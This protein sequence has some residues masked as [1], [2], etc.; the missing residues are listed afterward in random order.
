MRITFA[1]RHCTVSS[2]LRARARTLLERA[3]KPV[4]QPL[5][6]RVIFGA[7]HGEAS[8]ELRL[9]RGRGGIHIARG[10]AADHRTALDQAVAR[11]RRQLREAA[12]GRRNALRR[13][14]ARS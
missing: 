6:G 9:H 10:A 5:D 14:L 11:L 3:I 7:E 2:Q 13:P 1:T 4:A 12:A 8:V